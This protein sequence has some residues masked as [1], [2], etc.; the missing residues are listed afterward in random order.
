[1][2]G[3]LNI[4]TDSGTS[5]NTSANYVGGLLQ[6][7]NMILLAFPGGSDQTIE[8]LQVIT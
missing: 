6:V 5:H 1:L 7:N 2:G 4:V 8:L 3:P